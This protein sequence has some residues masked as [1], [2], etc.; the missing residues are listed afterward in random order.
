M[1]R[2]LGIM[3]LNI[4]IAM[5]IGS[6]FILL[7]HENPLRVYYYLIVYPFT[8]V[9]G[10]AKVLAKATPLIF[11]G[12]AALVC[13]RCQL[14]NVGVEGQIYLGA[15]AGSLVIL[16]VPVPSAVLLL[17]LACLTAMLVGG[18]WAMLAGWLKVRFRVHEVISTIMLNYVATSIMTYAVVDHLKRADGNYSRTENFGVTFT[19]LMPPSS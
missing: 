1:L 14:F 16:F 4:L 12:L 6:I 11:T 7:Q 13:F 18:L 15:L 5:V 17:L 3:L 10:L 19:K 8:T 2:D 9:G